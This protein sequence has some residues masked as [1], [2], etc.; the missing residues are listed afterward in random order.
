MTDSFGTNTPDE[1]P[2]DVWSKL[3]SRGE[4]RGADTVLNAAMAAANI[5]STTA[6]ANGLA[7][8]V[9]YDDG[10]SVPVVDM[11]P[12]RRAV[13]SRSRRSFGALGLAGILG[14]G[15]FA[16][17]SAMSN[18]GGADSP[19]AA[20]KE[21]ADAIGQEDMVAAIAIMSPT[22]VRSMKD[23]VDKASNQAETAKL[24]KSASQP[25][26]GIDLK[27]SNLELEATPMADGF[28]KVK[29][30]NGRVSA[31]TDPSK[32]GPMVRNKV[33]G[34]GN[35]TEDITNWKV[36]GV[37]PFVVTVRRDGGWYV[38]PMY[39]VFEYVRVIE[40]LPQADFGSAD[41]AKLGADSPDAAVTEAMRAISANDWDKIAALAPPSEFPLYEYRAAF[42][43][44]IG[45][46]KADFRIDDLRTESK[47]NGNSATVSITASG[48]IGSLGDG[49]DAWSV[50]KACDDSNY[51]SYNTFCLNGGQG[52]ALD[53]LPFIGRGDERSQNVSPLEIKAVKVDGR[54]FVSPVGTALD[55]LDTFIKSFDKDTLATWTGQPL[56][57][58]ID[59][60]LKLNTPFERTST[61]SLA[62]DHFTINVDG[63]TDVLPRVTVGDGEFGYAEIFDDSGDGITRTWDDA[64][65][66]SVYELPSAGRYHVIVPGYGQSRYTVTIWEAAKAPKLEQCESRS[67]GECF[68]TVETTPFEPGTPT[69]I[70]VEAC[71]TSA[72]GNVVCT[73]Q[74]TAAPIDETPESTPPATIAAGP[75]TSVA[76]LEP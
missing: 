63:P 57:T 28:T 22:E 15:G 44:L 67:N 68:T 75:T 7:T 30:I 31:K 45:D 26:A 6:S 58:S 55:Y 3:T 12:E 42:K 60:E 35:I 70:V 4:R 11:Q 8:T 27:I 5:V 40:G 61:S 46:R 69:S 13:R 14:I 53:L 37:D 20:V 33:D 23:T 48:S 24:V 38:S 18:S 50:G 72:N 9:T 19:T 32:F 62:A 76:P 56:E 34:E 66:E 74:T 25:F 47:V 59:G 54:W 29:I 49:G 16:G 21:L 52:T 1:Q 43:A 64:S 73:P 39:T 2:T 17:Y 36:E 10:V 41:A 51:D 65:G 71:S